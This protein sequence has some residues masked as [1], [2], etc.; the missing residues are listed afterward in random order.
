MEIGTLMYQE[1]WVSE[2][3]WQ[4]NDRNEPKTKQLQKRLLIQRRASLQG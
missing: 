1:K 2:K 3:D 4:G